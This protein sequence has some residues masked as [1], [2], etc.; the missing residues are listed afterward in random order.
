MKKDNFN[1]M[2]D[3]K[4]IEE[5]KATLISV[6]GEFYGLLAKGNNVAQGAIVECIAKAIM[7]L[8]ILGERL[9]YSHDAIDETMK[10]KLKLGIIE[11]DRVEKEGKSLSKLYN[12]LRDRN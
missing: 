1:I 8:Y 4:I 3:I 7:I 10:K 5:F 6:I 12:H 11:G 9:G 2:S